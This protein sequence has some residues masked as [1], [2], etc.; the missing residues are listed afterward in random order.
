[1]YGMSVPSTFTSS[2]EVVEYEDK[3]MGTFKF[4]AARD[5]ASSPS[6]CASLCMADGLKPHGKAACG[7]R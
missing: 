6:G 4:D 1:M 2:K 7:T 3:T 5:V